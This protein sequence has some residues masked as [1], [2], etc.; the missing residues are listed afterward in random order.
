M[1]V[2]VHAHGA[3]GM[4]RAVLAGVDSVEHGSFMTDEVMDLMIEGG[5]C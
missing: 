3:Q 1:W 5:T 2:A 4:K